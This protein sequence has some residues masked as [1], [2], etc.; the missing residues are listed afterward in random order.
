MKTPRAE[1]I[2]RLRDINAAMYTALK[3]VVTRRMESHETEA[4]YVPPEIELAYKAL[5]KADGMKEEK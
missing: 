5:A 1:E 3:A 2:K 4:A